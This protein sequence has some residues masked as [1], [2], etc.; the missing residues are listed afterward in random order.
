MT[1]EDII[2]TTN[3][4]KLLSSPTRLRILKT[5]F[6][7]N[8]EICVNEIAKKVDMSHS[9]VSH[10]LAK[11]EAKGIIYC[12]RRGKTMCYQVTKNSSTEKI[13]K[14]ISLFI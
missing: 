12:E 10:Q 5:L 13:K 1:N 2:K 6:G 14:A 8:N 9:A 4:F 7:S 3:I 11:L